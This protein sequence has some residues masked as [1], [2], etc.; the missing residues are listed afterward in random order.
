MAQI[1]NSRENT[2]I[3]MCLTSP[4]R[5]LLQFQ[6]KDSAPIDRAFAGQC[7]T[8]LPNLYLVMSTLVEVAF[9][10]DLV[11][12]RSIGPEQDSGSS[13][14]HDS[15]QAAMALSA[16]YNPPEVGWP[17]TAQVPVGTTPNW[18]QPT[19][20]CVWALLSWGHTH[21]LD[22]ARISVPNGGSCGV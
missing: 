8:A 2:N 4:L 15:E 22:G 21:T 13:A 11:V 19:C 10:A 9:G 18:A 7:N 5:I 16:C 1:P 20:V 14:S 12:R 3:Y 6:V 17:R